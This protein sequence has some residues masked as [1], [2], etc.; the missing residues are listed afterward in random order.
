MDRMKSTISA[1][2]AAVSYLSAEVS[3]FEMWIQKS[4]DDNVRCCLH[5]REATIYG[6]MQ[7]SLHLLQTSVIRSALHHTEQHRNQPA[8]MFPTSQP[9][10]GF[11]SS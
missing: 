4:G 10:S 11:V 3:V 9:I 2:T 5:V 7:R 6:I 8:G 1:L